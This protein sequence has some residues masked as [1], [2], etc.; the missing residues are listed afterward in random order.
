MLNVAGKS[1]GENHLVITPDGGQVVLN[2]KRDRVLA[3][4]NDDLDLAIYRVKGTP[5]IVSNQFEVAPADPALEDSLSAIGYPGALQAYENWLK[6]LKG[7]S[8]HDPISKAGEVQLK[9]CAG[10]VSSKRR[11]LFAAP[12]QVGIGNVSSGCSGGPTIDGS[13]RVVGCLVRAGF[14]GVRGS[15]DKVLYTDNGEYEFTP[16]TRDRLIALLKKYAPK[17]P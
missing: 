16:L 14:K 17:S 11:N 13:Q 10:M 2:E 15:D 6:S 9:G 8:D 3:S 12:A 1:K 7:E 4:Y 5:N